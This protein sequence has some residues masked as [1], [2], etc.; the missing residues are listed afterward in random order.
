[1]GESLESCRSVEAHRLCVHG[2]S[3]VH[4]QVCLVCMQGMHGRAS[5]R[6]GKLVWA[7]GT[8]ALCLPRDAH[9]T[10]LVQTACLKA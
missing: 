8:S 4:L 1:M 9:V 3:W 5:F 6:C 2:A 10:A 7:N